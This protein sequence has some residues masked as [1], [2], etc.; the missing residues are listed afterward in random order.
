MAVLP[1]YPGL[2][3]EILVDGEPLPEYDGDEGD[4]AYDTKTTYVE[5]RTNAEFSVRYTFEPGFMS[6]HLSVEVIV[7]GTTI[8]YVF[9]ASKD[10]L[11]G[12]THTVVGRNFNIGDRAY[13]Q[14]LRFSELAVGE[15][16]AITLATSSAHRVQWK[17]IVN[18]LMRS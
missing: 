11:R 10:L 2:T 13:V 16:W 3:V 1:S 17:A 18:Y 4:R 9:C 15:W 5:A 12:A 14:K 6:P 8:G 7:D